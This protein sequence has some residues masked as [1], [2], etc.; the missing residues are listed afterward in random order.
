MSI[1]YLS[2]RIVMPQDLNPAMR[3]FGGRALAWID[4]EAAIFA[5]C[6]LKGLRLVTKFMSEVNFVASARHGDV[7][8]FGLQVVACGRT[9]LTVRCVMRNK[10]TQ[11]TIVEVDRI[12]FVAVDE[13]DRPVPHGKT[14]EELEQNHN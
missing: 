4:E 8:E 5:L 7:V 1:R 13:E 12:V 11:N 14:L 3:L 2:R 6:Q 10:D 9:S